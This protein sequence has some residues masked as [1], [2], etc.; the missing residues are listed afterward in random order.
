MGQHYAGKEPSFR[1]SGKADDDVERLKSYVDSVIEGAQTGLYSYIAHPDII[2]FTGDQA[3]Y[4]SEMERLVVAI[5][6]EG[7][8]L[9]MNILGLREGRR[10]PREDFIALVAKH[11]GTMIVGCDAH[12]PE[13]VY[14]EETIK[15]AF[16]LFEKYGIERTEDLDLSRLQRL[17]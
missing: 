6:K 9:E 5:V 2:N 11:G 4:L 3:L 12:R 8:P 14:D 7:L 15:K 13:D 17:L 1:Y 10:Y 16:G